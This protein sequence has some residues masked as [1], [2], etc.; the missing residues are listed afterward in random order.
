MEGRGTVADVL[1]P[2]CQQVAAGYVMYG[3]STMLVYTT[4]QGVHGFTLDP[5]IGEFLLSHER[6]IT[7]RVGTLLQRQR[8]QLRPLGPGG[9]GG[10]ARAQGR[11]RPTA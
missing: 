5:T 3:S 4:G 6:I 11:H 9:A 2:G 10:R 8:E 7:P 1:Q